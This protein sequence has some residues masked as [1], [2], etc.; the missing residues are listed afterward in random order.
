ME[1]ELVRQAVKMGNSSGVYL[2]ISWL[3]KKV[4]VVLE[5]LDIKLDVFG[6][7]EEEKILEKVKGIYLVGSWARGEE[8]EESDID[9]LVIADKVNKKLKKGVYEILVIDEGEIEKVL[10]EDAIPLIVMIREAKTILNEGLINKY[11]NTKLGNRTLEKHLKYISSSIK[12]ISLEIKESQD[13]GIGVSDAGVYSLVLRL[14]TVYII[15]KL[16]GNELWKNEEFIEEIEN[17]SG[18]KDSYDRYLNVKRE[19]KLKWVVSIE[20][21]RK[22]LG[23]LEQK[24]NKIKK[25]TNGI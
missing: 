5:P 8:S 16:L 10:D 25:L 12:R 17:V 18:S 7:L 1:N 11:R 20:E 3:N 13:L 6:I 4:R 22:L 21:S 23:S 2:P 9:I 19:G 24:Y 14:R 15:E